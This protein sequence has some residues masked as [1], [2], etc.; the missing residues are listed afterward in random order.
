MVLTSLAMAYSTRFANDRETTDVGQD[1]WDGT[2]RA[3]GVGKEMEMKKWFRKWICEI[4]EIHAWREYYVPFETNPLRFHYCRRCAECNQIQEL[5]IVG[6]RS[7]WVDVPKSLLPDRQ[8]V[9]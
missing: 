4:F 8:E 9:S 5:V 2:T 6:S 1:V 7:A 3:K